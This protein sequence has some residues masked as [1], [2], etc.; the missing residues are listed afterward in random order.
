MEIDY[1]LERP[2]PLRAYLHLRGFTVL[3]GLS[4]EGKTSLLKAVAGLLPA[5]GMPFGG[6]PPQRRPV[7]YLP[8]GYG[9]F[10]HLRAW[11]NVAFPLPR[12]RNRRNRALELLTTVGIVGMAERYPDA[13][14]GGQQ[15][16]VAL[17]RALA[18]DPQLLLLDEPTSALDPATRDVILAE[19]VA[20]VRRVGLP[21]LAATHD[22]HLAV[23]ADWMAL[24]VGHRIVQE[25]TPRQVLGAPVSAEAARLVGYRNLLA[26]TVVS[27]DTASATIDVQGVRLRAGAPDWV[28]P[29]LPVGVAIRS[30]DISLARPG[31]ALPEDF[32]AIPLT[33]T[34]VQEE[35]LGFRISARGEVA[36][37]IL[38]SRSASI[39][40]APRAGEQ[41]LGLV[42]PEHVHLFLAAGG[43][44]RA[45]AFVPK[46][47]S[48]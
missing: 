10:P 27:R 47:G 24:M 15:Q 1:R 31:A 2:V 4:G 23:I 35:G 43:T 26:G 44:S 5:E 11:E 48:P 13:L 41:A 18:R 36:L 29:G 8:Q 20:Q 40:R 34:A 38:L 16:R 46:P 32:D 45:G 37:D 39:D 42:R 7:G 30:E 33:L 28:S 12:G 19:L 3:L 9:L 21:T 6:L 14:S 22:P 17:A 25:G